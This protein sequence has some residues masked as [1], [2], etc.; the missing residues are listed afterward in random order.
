MTQPVA[1]LVV[2]S[3][4]LLRPAATR[5]CAYPHSRRSRRR[6]VPRRGLIRCSGPVLR[7]PRGGA[8]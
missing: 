2:E 5:G 6:A 8:R 3:L 4:E 1:T 7:L